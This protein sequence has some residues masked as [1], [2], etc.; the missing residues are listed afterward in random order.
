MDIIERYS[1]KVKGILSTFDR[2]I[3][4]G[5]LQSFYSATHRYYYL[6]QEHVLLKDF[7]TYAQGITDTIKAHAKSMAEQSGR[8]YLYLNSPSISKEGLARQ[9]MEQDQVDE[10]L[11]CVLSTVELC[12]SFSIYRNRDTKK[13][14]LVL[15]NRKCLYFYFYYNDPELGFMHVRLQ[16]WFPF[17][18]QVYLNGREIL[19]KQLDKAGIGYERYEN[20]FV[21]IEDL[22][23]AQRFAERLKERRWHK[24]LDVFARRVNPLLDRITEIF[25]RGYYWCLHQCEYATDV[26]FESRAYVEEIVPELFE[27]ASRCFSADDIMTFLGR[28]IHGHFKGEVVSDRKRRPQGYRVRHRM[29]TNVIKMYDKWS[30]LRV[31]TIINQP[32]EFKVYRQTERKGQSIKAWVPMGKG[33][34][35]LYRYA[36]VCYAANMRYLNALAHIENP[37]KSAIELERLC[38]PVFKNHR[39]FSALNLLSQECCTLFSAVAHGEHCINGFT[40]KDIRV[41]LFTDLAETQKKQKSAQVTRL[42]A[43]LRAHRLIAKIPRSFRYK[44]TNK[45]YRVIS[46]TLQLKKIELPLA[47]AA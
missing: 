28:K 31:E 42:L 3:I 25:S 43:K 23:E 37:W 19:A 45:G 32:R 1:G 14:E 38:Y 16:S 9:I 39:R 12:R 34:G 5:H 27:Y 4:K 36:Q 7:G 44:V 29:K 22:V 2:M 24:I 21:S 26:M 8:P 47:M 6:Q 18:M 15:S 46:A 35:N 13:L 17:E 41:A 33:I 20:S 40:N 10:G 11:I 30:V